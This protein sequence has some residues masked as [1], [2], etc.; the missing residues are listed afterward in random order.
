MN[1]IK[2]LVTGAT[3]FIGNHTI[4]EL[5]RKNIHVIAT[6]SNTEKAQQYTWYNEVEY[7]ECD[8]RT[9][10]DTI[11][12]FYFFN[13][14]DAMIH[15]AWEGLPNYKNDFHITEN[16]PR[17][18]TFLQN[19]IVHG[20][21]NLT[22]VGT[23]LEYG[24]QEG[25]LSEDMPSIPSNPYAVAKNELR[26]KI[27]S[28]FTSY[29]FNFKWLRLFYMYGEGQNPNSLFSQLDKAI[30][31]GDEIFNMSGGQQIRDYLP[32]KKIAENIVCTALQKK[33]TGI[34]NC[35]SN[36]PVRLLD[37]IKQHLEKRKAHINLNTG[38]YPY[39]DYEPF[40]FW[41]NNNKL[42]Q[43]TAVN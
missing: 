24:M 39:P 6:S 26:K 30:D 18:F 28:L 21:K 42:K 15:L 19:L 36:E 5:L 32:V 25:E 33:T 41:G 16:L 17:H 27:E 13:R 37:M 10:D 23:C 3:G 35:C 40:S 14:P 9:I 2:V 8:L 34:I 31:N 22:V 4:Q 12:Y 1:A 29:S 38:F 43:I 20:L 11:D 7:I